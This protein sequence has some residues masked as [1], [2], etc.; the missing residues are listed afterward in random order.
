MS[1][2]SPSKSNVSKN[3]E[4]LE[5]EGREGARVKGMNPGTVL[6]VEVTLTA[7]PWFLVR[8]LKPT[9]EEVI[10]ILLLPVY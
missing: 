7:P 2:T 10:S 4:E 5:E 9:S 1:F 3:E 8:A 6:M